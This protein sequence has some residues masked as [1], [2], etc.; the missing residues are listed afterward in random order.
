MF[1]KECGAEIPEGGRFC[2]KCGT[3]ISGDSSG[4]ESIKS[5]PD[6]PIPAAPIQDGNYVTEY[7]CMCNNCGSVW[8][9]TDAD[10][11]ANKKMKTGSY[12]N[13]LSAGIHAAEGRAVGGAMWANRA[14][15][16]AAAVR[17]FNRCPTCGSYDISKKSKQIQL[18]FD[19]DAGGVASNG[20]K[21]R[22]VAGL[23]G[24]FLGV[25]GA[26]KFYL[27][28]MKQGVILL[29]VAFLGCILFCIPTV[30]VALIGIVEGV[31]YLTKSPQ[32]FFNTYVK[33]KKP[34]F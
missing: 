5:I 24:I 7:H 23:L 18:A 17:D 28:Y 6:K 9:F 19:G 1:C 10:M 16:F 12:L 33:N 22:V 25:L 21:S 26:Q 31:I 8:N 20:D 34:W 3:T 29:A 27:G 15:T 30:V 4:A 13:A 11:R 2:V 14:D 32:D